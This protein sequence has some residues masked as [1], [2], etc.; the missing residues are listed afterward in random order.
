MARRRLEIYEKEIDQTL[1]R[2]KKVEED[3]NYYRTRFDELECRLKN[4]LS[5]HHA[6]VQV[7][8]LRARISRNRRSC[9]P[10]K[11]C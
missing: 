10:T 7:S 2:L 1:L 4:L 6:Q 11:N 9:S 3:A 8:S 5:T